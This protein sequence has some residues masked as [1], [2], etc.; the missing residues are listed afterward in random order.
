MTDFFITAY[1]NKKHVRL[2]SF[3]LL[4]DNDIFRPTLSFRIKLTCYIFS[5]RELT[6]VKNN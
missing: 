2:I 5:L 4:M 3:Y 1:T 6:Q